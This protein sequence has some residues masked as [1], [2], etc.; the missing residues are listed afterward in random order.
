MN[1]NHITEFWSDMRQFE[2]IFCLL[3]WWRRQQIADPRSTSLFFFSRLLFAE[4]YRSLL[5][6]T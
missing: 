3:F 1:L 2:I 6:T 5:V 4:C